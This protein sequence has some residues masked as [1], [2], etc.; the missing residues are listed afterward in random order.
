M[1]KEVYTVYCTICS[2][3]YSIPT[4]A[5]WIISNTESEWCLWFIFFHGRNIFEANYFEESFLCTDESCTINFKSMRFLMS[6]LKNDL[7]NIHKWLKIQWTESLLFFLMVLHK[8]NNRYI[9][10]KSLFTKQGIYVLTYKHIY[11]STCRH[12]QPST[13][14]FK[15][16]VTSACSPSLC[17]DDFISAGGHRDEKFPILERKILLYQYI[18]RCTIRH[19]ALPEKNN[20][21]K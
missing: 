13:P 18:H 16:D 10:H 14:V 6:V 1:N 20:R 4:S 8:T 17:W 11:K 12:A 19:K 9:L 3:Q 7:E 2:K 21:N 5:L 15:E